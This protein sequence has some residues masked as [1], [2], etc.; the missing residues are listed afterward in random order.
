MNNHA[1]HF[2]IHEDDPIE[3]YPADVPDP[4]EDVTEP[5]PGL[6][7]R[8]PHP[9]SQPGGTEIDLGACCCK[10]PLD[11][12]LIMDDGKARGLENLP[13]P[14]KTK[15]TFGF[16]PC[17]KGLLGVRDFCFWAVWAARQVLKRKAGGRL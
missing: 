5:P 10:V 14:T 3:D 7:V 11:G 4:I 13:P 17:I 8:L 16:I 9:V 6:P 12:V 1:E 2:V 15:Q